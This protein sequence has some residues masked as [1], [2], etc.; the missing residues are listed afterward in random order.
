M[1]LLIR[2]RDED[3]T[4]VPPGAFIPAAER[5]GLML[6]L[7]RWVVDTALANFNRLHP[8]GKPVHLCAINLSALTVEDD[9]FAQ[10][11]LERLERYQV[12]ADRVCFE[13]TET[14]AVGQHG[15]RDRPDGQA[16]RGRLQVLA[17]RLR[18]RHGLLRLPEEPAGRLREDRRQLH[19]QPGDRS[20][21]LLDRARG[22]PTSATSWA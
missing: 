14:A 5:F 10:F 12:P 9:S 22:A 3:G 8:S 18:R 7:D 2:L 13:I 6:Q 19:P 17:R 20:D 21:Q 11:V 15:P 4:M 16:A 1:E